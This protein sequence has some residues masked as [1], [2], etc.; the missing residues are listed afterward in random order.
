M[1][2]RQ[3]SYAPARKAGG[4]ALFLALAIR[5]RLGAR[6]RDQRRILALRRMRKDK[7]TWGSVHP[8]RRMP[9]VGAPA[10]AD[11]ARRDRF[12]RVMRGRL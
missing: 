10:A 8:P 3:C 2:N 4:V 11:R 7:A 6:C 12:D 5:A 9:T 1:P